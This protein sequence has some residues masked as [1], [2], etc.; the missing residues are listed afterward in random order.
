[1]YIWWQR[2]WVGMAQISLELTEALL[3]E[4]ETAA[5]ASPEGSRSAWIR[6]AMRRR[7]DTDRQTQ[8]Q[9]AA[10]GSTEDA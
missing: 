1:M 6:I 8:P 9:I 5:E 10:L 2:Q 4:V 3:A 7:L